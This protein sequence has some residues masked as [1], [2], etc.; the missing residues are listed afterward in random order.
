MTVEMLARTIQIIL[1][2]VVMITACAIALGS[3]QSRYGAINDRLRLMTRERLDL[4]RTLGV[5]IVP[6]MPPGG[7]PQIAT[8][9]YAEERLIELDVQIPQLLRRH[10]LG[11]VAV[12]AA[13]YAMLVFIGDMF[14]IAAAVA[15]NASLLVA[16]AL[17]VFLVGMSVLLAGVLAIAEEVRS[18]HR[19]LR[20][21]VERVLGL[22]SVAHQ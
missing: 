1:A 5:Q 18:S 8:D 7:T 19:T 13:Y 4:L 14:V 9:A 22:G 20:Y 11:H 21:E 12:L 16:P 10:R 6:L 15:T 17:I 2:P 3:L